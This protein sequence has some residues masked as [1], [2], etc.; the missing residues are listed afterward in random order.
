MN[1]GNLQEK[2]IT[3]AM[4]TEVIVLTD[5]LNQYKEVAPNEEVQEKES[6]LKA[7]M[8]SLERN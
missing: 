6:R 8:D 7:M 3:D 2:A 4:L 5:W 1:S